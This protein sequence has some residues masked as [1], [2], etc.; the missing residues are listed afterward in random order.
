MISSVLG[1]WVKPKSLPLDRLQGALYGSNL[2]ANV[3]YVNSGHTNTGDSPGNGRSPNAP[4]ETVAYALALLDG[5]TGTG[6]IKSDD[7]IVVAAG[8]TETINAADA[9]NFL[10]PGIQILGQGVETRRP[11]I[12]LDTSTAA[13]IVVDQASCVL[14]GLR[15]VV[16]VDSLALMVDVQAAG[17][18]I[19]N[20]EFQMDASSKQAL[21]GVSFS[22]AAADKCEVLNCEFESDSAGANE[23][24]LIGHAGVKRLRVADCFVFGDFA[25]ACIQSAVV[26]T[27]CHITRNTLI[28]TQTGD[29]A[30]Q[31]SDDATG[32]IS[33]NAIGSS[34]SDAT[35]AG[36]DGGA[37][38][39]IENYGV[40]A[41]GNV[42]GLLD[43][44]VVS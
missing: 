13:S 7:V 38:H 12:T 17:V 44:V 21:V 6:L 5:N 16:D 37:C 29:H 39:M 3:W 33:Y 31:F 10:N 1:E 24:I 41:S 4:F 30:I 8:H 9:W 43:P 20:S 15:F 35:P 14:S 19:L 40:D 36:L 28:N 27:L 11:T 26:H 23:A 18:K 42:S 25:N 2:L 22:D 32:V 34:L